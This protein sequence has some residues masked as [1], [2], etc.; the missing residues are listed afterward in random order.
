MHILVVDICNS[1]GLPVVP[2][3]LFQIKEQKLPSPRINLP[4]NDFFHPVE[5]VQLEMLLQSFLHIA[6]IRDRWSFRAEERP[7]IRLSRQTSLA[8]R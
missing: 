6:L 5:K 8:V 1:Q 3:Y 4:K 2:Q 7:P